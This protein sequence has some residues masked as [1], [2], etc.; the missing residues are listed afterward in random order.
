VTA[1]HLRSANHP[2]N[3]AEI[4]GEPWRARARCRGMAVSF[5]FPP[6][7]EGPDAEA[8]VQVCAGCPVSAEC[9]DAAVSG[10]EDYGIWGGTTAKERRRRRRRSRRVG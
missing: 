2:L 5:F 4:A 7:E 10:K 9:L 1:S 8:A 6:D 3:A